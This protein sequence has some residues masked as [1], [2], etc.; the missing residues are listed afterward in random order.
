MHFL[1]PTAIG[2]VLLMTI[3]GLDVK[4]TE[5]W[6]NARLA[7]DALIKAGELESSSTTLPPT[8]TVAASRQVCLL[9]RNL[10]CP[11][12]GLESQAS[13]FPNSFCTCY[14]L[15]VLGVCSCQLRRGCLSYG[16]PEH[17]AWILGEEEGELSVRLS[18]SSLRAMN[19]PYVR[20]P[21]PRDKSPQYNRVA[22]AR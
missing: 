18:N 16:S 19:F 20:S 4:A 17:Q 7:I 9:S 12:S 11:T 15:D 6:P 14:L 5:G 10:Q 2:E 1:A 21:T 3:G 8:D 13:R 22:R